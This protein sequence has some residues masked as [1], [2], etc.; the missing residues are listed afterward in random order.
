MGIYIDYLRSVCISKEKKAEFTERVL[1][2]L[3]QGGM[4]SADW[5]DLHGSKLRLLALFMK[6]ELKSHIA[7]ITILKMPFIKLRISTWKMLYWCRRKSEM[8]S[9]IRSYFDFGWAA[10]L[11]IK[12]CCSFSHF[13]KFVVARSRVD[14]FARAGTS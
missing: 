11:R 10:R 7:A 9:L 12:R 3:R 5:V 1:K 14:L 2:I 4:F 6:R 8:K 13:N